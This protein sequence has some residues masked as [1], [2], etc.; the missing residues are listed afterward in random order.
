MGAVKY[1][2]HKCCMYVSSGGLSLYF[3]FLKEG[4]FFKINFE[5]VVRLQSRPTVCSGAKFGAHK[6]DPFAN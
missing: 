5:P 3:L 6:T 4:R 2:N 1:A